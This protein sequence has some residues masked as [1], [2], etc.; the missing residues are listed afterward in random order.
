LLVN[1]GFICVGEGG[2]RLEVVVICG[3]YGGWW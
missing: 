2:W 3:G 1:G